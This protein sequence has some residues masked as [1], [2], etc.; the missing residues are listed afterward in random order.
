M[1][2][3]SELNLEVEEFMGEMLYQNKSDQ[4]ILGEV[5]IQYRDKDCYPLYR[6]RAI[7]IIK[8]ERFYGI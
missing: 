7:Q 8:Q 5:E 3:M 6:Q 1:S 2:K 4:Y